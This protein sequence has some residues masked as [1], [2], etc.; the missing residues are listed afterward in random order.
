MIMYHIESQ[1]QKTLMQTR[2]ITS[3]P[4]EFKWKTDGISTQGKW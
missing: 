4:G 1:K 3:E 2:E